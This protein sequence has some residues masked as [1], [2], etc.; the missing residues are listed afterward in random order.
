[1]AVRYIQGSTHVNIDTDTKLVIDINSRKGDMSMYSLAIEFYK[2]LE[3][4]VCKYDN[5]T[6]NSIALS[7]NS[8]IYYIGEGDRMEEYFNSAHA[9]ILLVMKNNSN[10]DI[11]FF[12]YEPHGSKVEGNRIKLVEKSN[13]IFIELLKE[14]LQSIYKM[15]GKRCNIEILKSV[16]VSC[17]KGI[18]VY[19]NDSLGYC[20]LISTLWLYLVLALFS[21]KE[22][23]ADMKIELFGNLQVVETCLYDIYKDPKE[24]YNVVVNFSIDVLN[25][26]LTSI[27]TEDLV[28]KFHTKMLQKMKDM[29]LSVGINRVA[30]EANAQ[31]AMHE[32]DT[33]PGKDNFFIFND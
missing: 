12:L 31:Q 24:L 11:K 3:G 32:A 13:R 28:A 2:R 10:G 16:N 9:N 30:M 1:M 8:N 17:P 6:F 7:N 23:S 22:I 25:N 19:V 21:S 26:Y 5:F 33:H 14:N 15:K 27:A 20:K 29:K 4:S 18:Q